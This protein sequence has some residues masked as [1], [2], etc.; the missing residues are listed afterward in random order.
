MTTQR[1]SIRTN[2][3]TREQAVTAILA[4]CRVKGREPAVQVLALFKAK[5]LNEIPAARYGK[6]VD[7]CALAMTI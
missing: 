6:L 5:C 4:L 1:N 2:P 7:A 3:V